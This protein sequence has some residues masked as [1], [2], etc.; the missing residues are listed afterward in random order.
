MDNLSYNFFNECVSLSDAARKIFGKDDYRTCEKIK[1]IAS[2]YNFD[3]KIWGVR[4]KSVTVI[5]KCLYCGKDIVQNSGKRLKKFCNNSCAATYNNLKRGNNTKEDLKDKE[6]AYCGKPIKYTNKY[7]SK[8]CEV[9]YK[10]NEYIKKWQ[11]GEETGVSGRYGISYYIRS[12]L[13]RKYNNKCQKCGWGEIN[14][15]SGKVPLQIHHIDG[16][17]LNNSEDNLE[18]LCPNCHSLTDTFGNLNENS[19]RVFRRQKNGLII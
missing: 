12:Y 10:E 18:L 1:K 2:K 7:C 11:N 6:C 14:P 3:W 15:I 8:E 19:K 16:H 13:F 4:R 17:C 5:T 9:L